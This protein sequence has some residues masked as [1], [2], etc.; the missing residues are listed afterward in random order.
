[1]VCEESSEG[2]LWLLGV[3]MSIIASTCT[4][5]GVNLQKYSFLLEAK[6]IV[7]DKRS[8]LRQPKWIFGMLMVIIGSI[9]DFVALGFAPQTLITPVGG[10]TMVANVFFAH[11]FL[12]EDFNRRDAIATALIIA[13]VVQ[14]AFFADRS[15]KC[16]TLQELVDFYSRVAFIVYAVLVGLICIILVCLVKHI[17]HLSESLG[18]SSRQYM[19]FKR[20][21]PILYPA[22][23]GVFGAQSVLFAK[24]TAELIKTTMTG[25]NQLTNYGTYL[26]GCGML[27][28]IF[29]QIHWLAQGLQRFDAVFIVPVFQCFFIT[30]SIIGGGVYFDEFKIMSIFQIS[31]FLVGVAITLCGVFLLSQRPMNEIKP[32]QRFK[33]SVHAVIFIKRLQKDL[34]MQYQW[35]DSKPFS[36][37]ETTILDRDSTVECPPSPIRP[38]VDE[39]ETSYSVTNGSSSS[40]IEAASL[41]E[42][43]ASSKNQLGEKFVLMKAQV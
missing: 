41:K 12:N 40:S 34:G 36:D 26:I 28:C 37:H 3:F 4:N 27:T 21:H 38:L 8:Y 24:S 9:G 32:V 33:A 17:E 7:K 31:M 15:A 25:D 39:E 22:L 1:M 23:S 42:V 14:V 20:I 11:Y 5:L 13:G 19:R 35:V 2:S 10:F 29:L 16:F 30:V 6:R 43:S 18:S